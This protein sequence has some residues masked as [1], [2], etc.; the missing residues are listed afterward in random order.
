MRKLVEDSSLS[1][2]VSIDSAGTGHWHIGEPPDR[3]SAAAARKRQ[4]EITG[5]ARQFGPGDFSKFDY[6]LAMD[7]SNQHGLLTLAADAS[8]RDKIYL[9]R[10]FD[11]SGPEDADVP[12]PYYG[13]HDGFEKVID[14]CIAA[15]EGLLAHIRREHGL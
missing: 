9:F 14:I 5:R 10:N 2:A 11:P 6:V 7:R 13:G 3:R 8:A 1:H 15:C 4:I 12:D